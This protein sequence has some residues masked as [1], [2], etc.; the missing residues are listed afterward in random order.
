MGPG[1]VRRQVKLDAAGHRYLRAAYDRGY[2]SARGHQ[3]IL[4]VAR[5][6]ADLD[7]SDQVRADHVLRALSMRV[8]AGVDGAA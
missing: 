4:R 5:T 3:R 1:L 6:A 2:L 7:G 8:D